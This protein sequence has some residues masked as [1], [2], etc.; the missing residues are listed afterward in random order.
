MLGFS[1]YLIRFI[2]DHPEKRED[3]AEFIYSSPADSYFGKIGELATLNDINLFEAS[4]E[5]W[6]ALI[7]AP[8]KTQS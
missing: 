8:E 1:Y 2:M 7:K 5:T 3:V 6:C 4:T